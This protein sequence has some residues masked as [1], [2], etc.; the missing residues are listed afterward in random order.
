MQADLI[1]LCSSVCTLC[2]VQHIEGVRLLSCKSTSVYSVLFII[3][4]R[5]NTKFWKDHI[6]LYMYSAPRG[7]SW[8]QTLEPR[9]VGAASL[10]CYGRTSVLE[11]VLQGVPREEA[12][13]TVKWRRP[14][15]PIVSQL[16]S[17]DPS[18]SSTSPSSVTPPQ[19]NASYREAWI[20]SLGS[21]AC[22]GTVRLRLSMI[23]S[24]TGF[25]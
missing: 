8:L 2:I 10:W 4:Y 5:L 16:V 23:Q 14:S 12:W 6:A 22:Y 17:S 11:F 19:L 20:R 7:P 18:S 15:T 13:A 25:P 24:S 1:S 21:R 9:R 3:D